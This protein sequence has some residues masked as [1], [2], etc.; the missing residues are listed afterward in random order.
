MKNRARLLCT[1]L[2]RRYDPAQ[3]LI[4]LALRRALAGCENVLDVGCGARCWT[5]RDLGLSNTTGIEAY[6]PAF[7]EAERLKTHDHLV[8]GDARNLD[9]W[10]EP[11][12]FDACVAVDVIEHLRKEDGLRLMRQMEQVALKRVVFFT[13]S[14]FLPQGH[15]VPGDL[16]SHLSGWEP[17][18]MKAYG[19]QVSG[20]LGPKRLRGQHHLLIRPSLP[21]GLVSLFGHFLWTRYHP[22]AAA[23]MLCVKCLQPTP[24]PEAQKVTAPKPGDFAACRPMIRT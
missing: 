23:A 2:K 18:E 5:L 10:F 4:R 9:R 21:W 11:R 8:F 7:R 24:V 13:P 6:E 22:E 14:G 3:I 16:Q 19:Y 12:Q 1:L 20:F 17:R 15:R